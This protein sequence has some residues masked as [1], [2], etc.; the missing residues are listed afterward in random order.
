M[1]KTV[2]VRAHSMKEA[3]G[4]IYG[5]IPDEDQ[6]GIALTEHVGAEFVVDVV[7]A[8]EE[9]HIYRS[10]PKEADQ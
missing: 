9:W 4:I 5:H 6:Q 10:T 2:R 1:T 8:G 7:R 3:R